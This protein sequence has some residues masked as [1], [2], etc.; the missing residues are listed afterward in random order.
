[1]KLKKITEYEVI[2]HGFDQPDYFQGCG[3]ALTDFTFVVTGVGGNEQQAYEDALEQLAMDDWD[4][5]E[6]EQHTK[7]YDTQEQEYTEEELEQMDNIPYYY[8]SIRVR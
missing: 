3:I 5:D 6:L 2:S 1:M 8:L 4:I 7:E